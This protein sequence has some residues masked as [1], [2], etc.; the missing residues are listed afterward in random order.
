MILRPGYSTSFSEFSTRTKCFPPSPAW[1]STCK[2]GPDEKLFLMYGCEQTG[3]N[4][5]DHSW[6]PDSQLEMFHPTSAKVL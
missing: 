6:Q 5:R 1:K 4:F 2:P 3:S